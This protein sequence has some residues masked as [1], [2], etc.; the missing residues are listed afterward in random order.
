MKRDSNGRFVGRKTK[1]KF[2][3]EVVRTISA[4]LGAIVSSV[5]LWKVFHR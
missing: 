1:F 5:V 2:T 4:L 3:M